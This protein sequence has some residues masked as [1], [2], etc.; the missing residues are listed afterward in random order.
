MRVVS[1]LLSDLSE[2]LHRYDRS[3]HI[4]LFIS[5]FKMRNLRIRTWNEPLLLVASFTCV[6]AQWL[7]QVP[8]DTRSLDQIYA[9]AKSETGNLQVFFG[10]DGKLPIYP[11]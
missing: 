8:V 10:G 11:V 3:Q 6:F 1:L 4:D 2:S 5:S 7:P 9:V